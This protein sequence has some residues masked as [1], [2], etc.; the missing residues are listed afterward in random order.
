MATTKELVEQINS[1][2]MEN[3]MEAFMDYLAE[4]VIWDMYTSSS[5]HHTFNGLAEI[6]NMDGGDFPEQTDFQFTTIVIEGNVASVQG[7]NTGK[8]ADGK[9]YSSNF[10]DVYHFEENKIVKI[11]SYVID[12]RK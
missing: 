4:D 8:L 6:A 10:C 5:G 7:T 12:N 1:L 11:S 9:D 2:F 3:K